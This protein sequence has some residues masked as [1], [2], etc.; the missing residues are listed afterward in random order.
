MNAINTYIN[1]QK[2]WSIKEDEQKF[3]EVI[4]NGL[5]GIDVVSQVITAFMPDT[6]ARALASIGKTPGKLDIS[7]RTYQL[8]EPPV[9][10]PRIEPKA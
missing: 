9:L 6:G 3:K 5:Y 4:Y 7:H 8:S 1:D 2:P 10:F